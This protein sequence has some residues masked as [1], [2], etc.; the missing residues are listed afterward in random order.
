MNGFERED[1]EAPPPLTPIERALSALLTGGVVVAI[2]LWLIW[3][4]GIGR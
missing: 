3:D 4:S 2:T 1:L